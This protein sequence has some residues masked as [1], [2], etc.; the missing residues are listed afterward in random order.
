MDR[1]HVFDLHCDTLDSLAWPKLPPEL[2]GGSV[3]YDPSDEGKVTPGE[4]TDFADAGHGHLSLPRMGRFAWCQ[5]MAV[6]IPDTLTVEQS[7]TFFDIVSTTLAEH[8]RLHPDLLAQARSAG[9][10]DGT[11]ES[12]RTCAILTIENGKLLASSSDMIDHVAERGVRMLTLTWN[13]ANPLGSGHDTEQPLTRFG[14]D[15]VTSLEGHRIVVDVSHL[16][17]PGFEDVRRI[18]RRPFVASHSNSRAVMDVPRNLTD[19]QFRAIRDAGGLVGLNFCRHFLSPSP[20]PTPAEVLAHV[21]HW[22]DL[23]GQDVVCLGSDYDGCDVPSWLAPAD[24]VSTLED[25]LVADIG[26]ELTDKLLFSN[27]HDFFVR[28]ETD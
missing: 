16:N 2:D 12:G 17:D 26:R 20:D 1:T 6:F 23:D 11:L 14:R 13:A 21:E 4:L 19:D 8:I 22:L 9:Q 24:H 18:A 28:N 10:I 7:A 15:M 27:A 5:C 3:F 25:A